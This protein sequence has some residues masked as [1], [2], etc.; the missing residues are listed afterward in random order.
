MGAEHNTTTPV[1][2]SFDARWMVLLLLAVIA[3]MLLIWKPWAGGNAASRTIEVSGEATLTAKPDEFVFY[4]S[5]QFKNAD[6]SAALSE[7]T[8]KSDEIVAKLKELGVADK[9]IKTNASGYDY[10]V[11]ME[12]HTRD[13]TY[14]LQLTVTVAEE[15]LAQKVQDYLLTTSPVG[16][17]SPV[18]GFSKNKRKQLEA[19]ARDNATKDARTKADQMA[20]NLGFGIGKVKSVNSGNGFG[21]QPYAASTQAVAPDARAMEDSS[22]SLQPG[23]NELSYSVTVVYFIR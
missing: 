16:T 10:P 4:P 19:T 6:K 11:S 14:T 5:Y 15:K 7:V 17:V 13:V 23:E 20:K 3:G 18:A 12:A 22:L 1:R 21:V 2:I 9:H 8:K